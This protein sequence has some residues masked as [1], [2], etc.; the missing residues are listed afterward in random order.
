M[1]HLDGEGNIIKT[2]TNLNGYTIYPV[3]H[4]LVDVF[5]GVGFANYARF[6]WIKEKEIFE[7]WKKNK[8]LPNGLLLTLLE[9]RKE[10]KNGI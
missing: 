7:L 4:N 10:K 6:K 8:S 3:T 5:W 9:W 2:F 1:S